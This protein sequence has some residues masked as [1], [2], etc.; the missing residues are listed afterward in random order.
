MSIAKMSFYTSICTMVC[1][2]V[3]AVAYL[4]RPKYVS[5]HNSYRR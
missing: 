2:T 4:Q 3:I 1:I 5:L